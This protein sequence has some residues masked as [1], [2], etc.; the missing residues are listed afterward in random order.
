MFADPNHEPARA[1]LA[2]VLTRLGYG[3]ECATWRNNYLTGAQELARPGRRRV[4]SS[5]GMAPALTVTQLFDS[6]AIR[7]DGKRAWDATASISWHFTD[8][9][10]TYRMEL[11]QRRADPPPDHARRSPPTSSSPSPGRSCWRCSAGAG[12]D[13]VQFEGT[14]QDVRTTSPGFADEPDPTFAIVT[15]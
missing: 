9:G 15:P 11:S 3:A 12:T 10:E 6:L 2:D 13:G 1:L 14:P 5:A 8:T 7:I 4:V